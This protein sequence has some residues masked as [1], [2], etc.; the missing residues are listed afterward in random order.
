MMLRVK[1]VEAYRPGCD[2][3]VFAAHEV[4]PDGANHIFVDVG[5]PGITGV[6][7]HSLKDGKMEEMPSKIMTLIGCA[8][9]IDTISVVAPEN[10]K[11]KR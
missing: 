9:V 3:P 4:S 1:S 11:K 5:K 10:G 7:V 6:F 2:E 8:I